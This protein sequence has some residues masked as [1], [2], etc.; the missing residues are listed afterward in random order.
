MNNKIEVP[1]EYI[2]KYFEVLRN[3]YK[4]QIKQKLES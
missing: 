2:I 4:N 3:D 1:P